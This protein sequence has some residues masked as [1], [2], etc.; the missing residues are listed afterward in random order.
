[1]GSAPDLV[2]NPL[3]YIAPITM[4]SGGMLKQFLPK[5]PDMPTPPT[6][7]PTTPMPT[8]A[9]RSPLSIEQARQKKLAA[10]Q[11]GFAST[12]S[13]SRLNTPANPAADLTPLK[14][15]LGQ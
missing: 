13:K 3:T 7:V 14:T 12:I 6:V 11:Y 5:A 1:M 2:K 8:M 4:I 10:L 9:S 15:R